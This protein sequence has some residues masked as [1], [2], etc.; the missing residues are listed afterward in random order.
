M[1]GIPARIELT[2]EYKN[3]LDF[4][5]KRHHIDNMIS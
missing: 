4:T 1:Q 2:D 3:A 5:K